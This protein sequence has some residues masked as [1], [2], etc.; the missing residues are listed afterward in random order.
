[1]GKTSN[2]NPLLTPLDWL[3]IE[4]QT[5]TAE[6]HYIVAKFDGN[7]M[8]HLHLL[9]QIPELGVFTSACIVDHVRVW[10]AEQRHMLVQQC[11]GAGV[12]P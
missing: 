12:C 6:A 1:M 8:G 3:L 5:M 2:L 9:A 7:A 4:R 10:T 11:E